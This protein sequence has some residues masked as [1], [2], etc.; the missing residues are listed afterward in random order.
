MH[1]RAYRH[2]Q[3]FQ[4]ET[5]G[6]AAILEDDAQPSIYFARDFLP[7]RFGVFF[8][9]GVCS[10]SSKGRKRQIAALTSTNSRLNCS[11]WRYSSISCSALRRAAGLVKDSVTV[12]PSAL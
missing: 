9:A 6:L 11:H 1:G 4:I 3:G 7:D 2:L 8:S 12:L 10:C 5:A